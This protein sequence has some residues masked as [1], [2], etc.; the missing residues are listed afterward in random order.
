MR[1][2]VLPAGQGP[3]DWGR[4]HG[5]SYRGE[6]RDLAALRTHLTVTRGGFLSSRVVLE[7]AARHL[8]VLARFDAALHDE[9]CGIAD[10]AGISAAEAVVI[11][12]YTDLRDIDP[13]ALPEDDCS[14]IFARCPGGPVLA[15]TCDTH[16]T[17]IPY[18]M[19]LHVPAHETPAGP[20][21]AAWL[22]SITGCLGMT[23]MS[24]RGVAVAI[25]NLHG[26]DAR[27]GVVWPALVR[28]L[29]R[30]P[31][32]AGARDLLLAGGPG[33]SAV[34][35]GRHYL[36]ADARE[37]FA[38]E[39]S[40]TQRAQIYAGDSAWFVHTNHALHPVV[41]GTTR[42]SPDS[43]THE[44]YQALQAS[45]TG[46]APTGVQDVWQRLGARDGYPRSVC[47]NQATPDRPHGTATCAGIAMELAAGRLWAE[48]GFVHRAVPQRF[49]FTAAEV[50]RAGS[51]ELT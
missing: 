19:M 41:A 51:W 37:A 13:A 18:V 16:V 26:T 21:P 34:A 27:I 50:A 33:R 17:A 15:Q 2:L 9:L 39:A 1:T 7:L 14:L 32:A 48:A 43:S 28:R 47:G 45:L 36:V 44:R 30:A 35:S 31:G 11:N 40:G 4:I 38:V 25:N 3:R 46:R 12:H 20:A 29:L 42:V 22:L 10:G 5:E 8:P 23:G 24:Q 6:I 49:G